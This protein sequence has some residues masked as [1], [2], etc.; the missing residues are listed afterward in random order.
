MNT[1]QV[2]MLMLYFNK[3]GIDSIITNSNYVEL[4]YIFKYKTNDILLF[5]DYLYTS[6]S[7]IFILIGVILLTAMIGAIVLAS[8]ANSAKNRG[9]LIV[10]NI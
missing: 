4:L 8:S 3:I 9:Y 2:D 10:F 7:I 6:F 1:P 5:S